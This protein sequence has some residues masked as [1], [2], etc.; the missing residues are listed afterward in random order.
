MIIDALFIGVFSSFII[1]FFYFLVFNNIFNGTLIYVLPYFIVFV[2][3]HLLYNLV[4]LSIASYY[5]VRYYKFDIVRLITTIILDI[6]IY[7]FA[8]L[9][10]IIL[11]TIFYFTDKKS[12]N[13]VNRSGRNYNVLKRS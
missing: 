8:I 4:G 13:K 1:I 6:T 9:C 2:S 3:V 11:G 10:T 12:W 5:N 7:R